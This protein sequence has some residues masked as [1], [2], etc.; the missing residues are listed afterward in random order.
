[1]EHGD[2]GTFTFLFTDIEGS[3]RRWEEQPGVMSA[4]VARHDALL[5]SAIEAHGGHVFKTVGDAFCAAFHTAQDALAAALAV[6]YAVESEDWGAVGALR[7]RMALHT[8]AAETRDGDYFGQTLN[9]VARIL[10][11]G[12]GGQ[13]L[14]SE[15]S[16]GLVRDNLLDGVTHQDMGEH[17][18]KDLMRPERIFQVVAPNLPNTFPPLKTL[19]NRPNNLPVQPTHLIGREREIEAVRQRLL[20]A[21]TRLLT[22]T[23]PGGTGKTRLALQVAAEVVDEFT[24]GVFFIDLAPIRDPAL[25]ISEIAQTLGVRETAGRPLIDSLKDYLREKRLLLLLDNFEQ[26][27]EAAPEVAQLVQAAPG[28]KV[29]ATS[30]AALHLRGEKEYPVPPLSLPDPKNLPSL[31]RLNQYEAVRLFIE[32]A[33]DAKPDF[34]VTNDNAPAVV[35]ICVRLDGLPLAIELAAARIKILPPQAILSRLQSRLKVLTGGA[36]D[37]PARQQT[38]RNTIEWSYDLLDEEEK[39]LFRWLAVFVGGCTLEAIAEVGNTDGDLGI[40]VLDGVQSLVDKSLVKQ[41]E[42]V[43]GEPRFVMLETIHE[44][45]GEKLEESGEGEKLRRRHVRYFLAFAEEAN[46]GL[47]GAKSGEWLARLAEEHD[48]MR[49]ILELSL[50]AGGAEDIEGG[51]HLAGTLWRFWNRHGDLDEGRT[52]L[53][54]LLS[55]GA[56]EA[57]TRG[58]AKALF[59]AGQLAYHQGDYAPATPLLEESLIIYR[60]LDDAYNTSAVLQILGLL[61]VRRANYSSARALCEESVE[62]ERELQRKG[63]T[64]MALGS[65]AEV[66]QCQGDYALARSLCEES[67]AIFRELDAKAGIANMLNNLGDVARYQHNYAEAQSLYEESLSLFRKITHKQGIPYPLLSLGRLALLEQDCE[68]ARGLLKDSL[69][70]FKELSNNRRIAMCLI[71]LAALC[72]AEDKAIQ[73]AALYGASETAFQAIGTLIDPPERTEYAHGL[74]AARAQLDEATWQAAWEEGRAMSMEEAIAY[75]LETKDQPES[76]T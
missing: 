12:H 67:L 73:A 64:A 65:L 55:K 2:G 34:E 72:G 25:V 24:G 1:M 71:E 23:G 33:T 76:T 75:A 9:R 32:R 39:K 13:T 31:E 10:S 56:A 59:A 50:A 69:T 22:L 52:R 8:G 58:R 15:V 6:Q 20:N 21:D 57:H 63:G 11:A 62:I 38:L 47:G 41:Q 4:A 46:D 28:L 70:R 18:L 61:A 44:F 14:L 48:N 45:A 30:R 35:E 37:L 54:A 5:R 53:V 29:L 42:G 66:V 7:V 19:D 3:T 51:L 60:E 16:Y 36:R 49:A 68:R 17:R 27:L 43:G 26:V 40:D 74:A